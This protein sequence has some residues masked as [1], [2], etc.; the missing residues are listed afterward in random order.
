LK[1]ERRIGKEGMR[2]K[3]KEEGERKKTREGKNK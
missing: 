1:I 2:E 3:D